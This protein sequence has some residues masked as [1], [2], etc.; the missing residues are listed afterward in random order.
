MT[1][2]THASRRALARVTDAVA[3]ATVAPGFSRIGISLRRQLEGWGEP[4]P[5][6][7]RV[8]I[9]TGATSGI[10]LATAT[11]LAGLGAEVHLVGR[12]PGRGAAALGAVEAVGPSRAHLHLVDLSDPAAV[13]ALGK[14]PP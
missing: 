1:V 8:A 7:G 5:M 13:V 3:E 2:L 11:A 6:N 14:A 12:D 4:P 9:V 10:G